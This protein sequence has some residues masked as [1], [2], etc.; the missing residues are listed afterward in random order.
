MGFCGN[1]RFRFLKNIFNA[2]LNIFMACLQ[3]ISLAILSVQLIEDGHQ[4]VM[5]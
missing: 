2:V 4:G 5:L 1:K 3:I